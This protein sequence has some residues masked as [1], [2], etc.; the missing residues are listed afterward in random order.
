MSENG[1]DI[2][3]YISISDLAPWRYFQYRHTR[4]FVNIRKALSGNT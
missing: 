1:T 3:S 4:L 2:F